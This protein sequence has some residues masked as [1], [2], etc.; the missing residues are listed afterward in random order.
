VELTLEPGEGAMEG[1]GN[2]KMTMKGILTW[3]VKKFERS[4]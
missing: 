2:F 4:M 3:E 1:M